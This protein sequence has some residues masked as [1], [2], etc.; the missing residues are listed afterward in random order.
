MV[1]VFLFHPLSPW[2]ALLGKHCM[3]IVLL[4]LGASEPVALLLDH[5]L[6]PASHLGFWGCDPSRSIDMFSVKVKFKGSLY[7]LQFVL[8]GKQWKWESCLDSLKQQHRLGSASGPAGSRELNWRAGNK[9]WEKN[10]QFWVEPKWK[11][12]PEAHAERL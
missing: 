1:W 3:L 12:H 5:W 8:S 4:S 9:A 7:L 10:P 11:T 6:P 2:S